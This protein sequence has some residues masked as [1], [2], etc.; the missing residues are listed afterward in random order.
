MPQ[1]H[2]LCCNHHLTVQL[3]LHPLHSSE[4]AWCWYA[5]DFSEKPE[6]VKE[7]LAIKFK[8]VELA[9]EFKTKFEECQEQLRR[10]QAAADSSST[11]TSA[12][13]VLPLASATQQHHGEED[14]ENDDDDEEGDEEVEDEE[15]EDDEVDTED[16]EEED[17][18]EEDDDDDD[19]DDTSVI[20]TERCTLTKKE[21][22]HWNV[23][24][25]GGSVLLM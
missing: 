18:E 22:D 13:V 25:W 8:T 23:S 5:I 4:T 6:G 11:S 2:K 15:E 12:V 21:K 19:D 14:A 10:N 24:S 20:F 16:E 1:V 9:R 7:Q 3:E 17:E